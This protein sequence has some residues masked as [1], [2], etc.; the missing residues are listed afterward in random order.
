M[1]GIGLTNAIT[2]GINA[3]RL[4]KQDDNQAVDRQRLLKQQGR[5]DRE[6]EAGDAGN[7]AANAVVRESMEQHR[8]SGAQT[9]YR[10][11]PLTVVRAFDARGG[12]LVQGGNFKAF[13]ENEAVASGARLK[14]RS[15]F[16]QEYEQNQD[17]DSLFRRAYATF[18]DGDQVQSVEVLPAAAAAPGAQAAAP[19]LRIT[20]TS[21]KVVEGAQD[22]L[23][24][25][26]VRS[27]QDPAATAQK[28]AEV[29]FE[30]LKS[31]AQSKGK[32]P[33]EEAKGLEDRRTEADK[34]KGRLGLEA[35]EGRNRKEVAGIN[36][37]GDI[38]TAKLRAKQSERDKQGMRGDVLQRLVINS[39]IGVTDPVTGAS[40]GDES[41]NAVALRAEHWLKA[42]PDMSEV[43]AVNKA[44]TEFR[45]R[46]PKK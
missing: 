19:M 29:H 2:N 30:Y 46:T 21:G 14:A 3:E 32:V 44:V 28:E 11:D 1:S 20:K 13:M 37:A 24:G 27:L 36:V 42:Y 35:V 5:Q 6:L 4:R 8:A 43:E 40:R 38:E 33:L 7:E 25:A 16:L 39:G 9:P 15:Q 31:L 22:K 41:S 26:I 12:A 18:P 45:A 17:V 34:Q 23:I 10:P